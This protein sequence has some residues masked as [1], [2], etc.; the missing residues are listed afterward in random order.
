[1][2]P[3]NITGIRT[4]VCKPRTTCCPFMLTSSLVYSAPVNMQA[5]HV[6]PKRRLAFA[7]LQGALSQTKETFIAADMRISD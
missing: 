2:F 3:K 6:P 4:T 7:G 5:W 1:M